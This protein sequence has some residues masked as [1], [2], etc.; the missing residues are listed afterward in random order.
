MKQKL[1]KMSFD[2]QNCTTEPKL[3]QILKI[4]QSSVEEKFILFLMVSFNKRGHCIVS[5][6]TFRK[7]G[8]P[9][10]TKFFLQRIALIVTNSF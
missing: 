2:F 4:W 9:K 7:T 6:K 1:M 5:Y 10:G 3:I 8:K